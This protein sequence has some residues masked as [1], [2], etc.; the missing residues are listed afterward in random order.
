MSLTLF[1]ELTFY[2]ASAGALVLR[3]R[4]VPAPTLLALGGA[5]CLLVAALHP[6]GAFAGFAFWTHFFVGALAWWTFHRRI[7]PASFGGLLAALVAVALNFTSAIVVA[8]AT[9]L[10]LAVAARHT[11]RL[12]VR[13]AVPLVALG[14]ASYSLYL[15]CVTVIS[16]FFNLAVCAIP[17]PSA[18]FVAVWLAGLGLAV[19]AGLVFDHGIERPCERWH[20]RLVARPVS[21]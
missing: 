16:P 2:T 20:R 11:L 8:S 21:A 4:G 7:A 6:S 14:A 17:F 19:A 5:G 10:V 13:L 3:Q 12:P 18:A 1:H 15:I 9:A